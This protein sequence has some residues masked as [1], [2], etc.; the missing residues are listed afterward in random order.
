MTHAGL[1]E[2]VDDRRI[3]LPALDHQIRRDGLVGQLAHPVQIGAPLGG[4]RFDHPETAGLR[5]GRGEF[6]A[7]D[8]GHRGLNDGILDA[9]QSLDA[10]GHGLFKPLD[11]RRP[12][13]PREILVAVR[14][15]VFIECFIICE[16]PSHRCR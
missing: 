8:I 1:G 13:A 11:G 10:V 6:G 15:Q 16:W 4:E 5:D 2:H 7:R 12:P 14:C 3:L 9:E